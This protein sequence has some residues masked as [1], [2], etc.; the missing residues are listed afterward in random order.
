M[1]RFLVVA[2]G[3]IFLPL[4]VKNMLRME[5]RLE[6]GVRRELGEGH[7]YALVKVI[8]DGEESLL[9]GFGCRD[10]KSTRLNSS[11]S[12]KSRMPSSA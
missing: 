6:K 2:E 7:E 11:H 9:G 8:A 1:V 5:V 10:R 12:R 4:H 3:V